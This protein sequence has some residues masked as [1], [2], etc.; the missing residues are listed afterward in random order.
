MQLSLRDPTYTPPVGESRTER[1]AERF[2]HDRRDVPF[3]SLMALTSLTVIPTGLV[4]F[5][6]GQFRWWLAAVHLV[7][8][9]YFMG[10]FVLMLHNTSHRRL[11]KRPWSWMNQYI[12]WVLGPF[13]GESPETYFAHHVGMH[14]PENNLEDDLSCTMKYQRDSVLGFIHYFLR[15]FVG[16]LPELSV[17][18]AKR[19]RRSLMIRCMIGELSFFAAVAGL[20]YLD[21]RPALVV[22]I[23]PFI[24]TRFA[25]MAGNWGQH[26]FIDAASPENCYRNSITCINSGYNKR[27]FN[28][29]YHIGH[30]IKQT[31]HWTEMPGDFQANVARYEE[32]RAIVFEKLDFFLVW[33]FLM[34]GRYDWLARRYVH[35]GAVRPSEEEIIGLLRTRTARI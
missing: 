12:P 27:C 6:P 4:L 18:L 25:M 29:G 1:V 13:F 16:A 20:V 24:I 2:I 26:A 34:L 15:F 3:L 19:K 23:L 22:F 10:P 33:L 5:V 9:I 35:L 7:L 17:Y 32:E 21:W 31:R 8:V 28:D 30:H 14:H 11:F